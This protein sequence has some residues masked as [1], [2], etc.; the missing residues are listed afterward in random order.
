M[1]RNDNI[2]S[3]FSLTTSGPR[4]MVGTMT[5]VLVYLACFTSFVKVDAFSP[6]A[7]CLKRGA[8]KSM[9]I[10]PQLKNRSFSRARA[11]QLFR[12][13]KD[14]EINDANGFE[15]IS[16]FNGDASEESSSAAVEM[17]T[18]GATTSIDYSKV[19]YAKTKCARRTT[20]V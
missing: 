15:S 8:M 6:N 5:M 4:T 16:P 9:I 13:K 7:Q 14:N 10:T 20:L 11:T 18:N 1:G 12:K 19:T 2:Y 3:S 17:P